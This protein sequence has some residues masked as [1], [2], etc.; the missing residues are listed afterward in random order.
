MLRVKCELRKRRRNKSGVCGSSILFGGLFMVYEKRV[1]LF[2]RKRL[3]T[4]TKVQKFRNYTFFRLTLRCHNLVYA[5][6]SSSSLLPLIFKI[7]LISSGFNFL[8]L[9]Y[10]NSERIAFPILLSNYLFQYY[11][12][13]DRLFDVAFS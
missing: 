4:S 13:F 9:C 1:C 7:D 6:T 2:V 8:S 3:K 10:E 12:N 11:L 5:P